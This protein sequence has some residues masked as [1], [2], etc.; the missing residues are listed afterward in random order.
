M[1]NR[2]NNYVTDGITLQTDGMNLIIIKLECSSSEKDE[3]TTRNAS[4]Q[5]SRN[6]ETWSP[7]LSAR[8]VRTNPSNIVRVEPRVNPALRNMAATSPYD[9]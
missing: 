2:R 9:C 3:E 6:G 4:V 5:F 8:S 1:R 7:S